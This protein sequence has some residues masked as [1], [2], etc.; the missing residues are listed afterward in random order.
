M[1]IFQAA[2]QSV[3]ILASLLVWLVGCDNPAS[4]L[5]PT[6][7]EIVVPNTLPQPGKLDPS[8]L[9]PN[10]WW[11]GGFI[12]GPERCIFAPGYRWDTETAYCKDR[13]EVQQCQ[14]VT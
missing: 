5:A 3:L 8:V 9:P 7:Q 2:A 11:E 12:C 14:R 10:D 1:M 6:V 13:P 4:P